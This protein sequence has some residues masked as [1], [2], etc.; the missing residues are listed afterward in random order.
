M[1]SIPPSGCLSGGFSTL[2]PLDLPWKKSPVAYKS[3]EACALSDGHY[4]RAFAQ[5]G[6]MIVANDCLILRIFQMVDGVIR[7]EVLMDVMNHQ[8]AER[9]AQRVQA[10]RE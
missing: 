4:R 5:G 10:N 8:Q 6:R 2:S 7:E 3:S 9:E 1:C